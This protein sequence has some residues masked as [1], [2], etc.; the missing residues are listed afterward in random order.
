LE[1]N[2]TIPVRQTERMMKLQDVILKAMAKKVSW[3]EAA[4]IAGRLRAE[5]KI[6]ILNAELDKRR[7][8]AHGSLV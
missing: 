7:I 8:T 5:E 2:Q 6:C 3:M 1:A 4:E